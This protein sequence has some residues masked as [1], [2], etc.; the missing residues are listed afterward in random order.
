MGSKKNQQII[1]GSVIKHKGWGGYL[2]S[3]K[4]EMVLVFKKR[5]K[6]LPKATILIHRCHMFERI[7]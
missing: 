6:E 1:S 3:E 4:K 2:I 7:A 5:K